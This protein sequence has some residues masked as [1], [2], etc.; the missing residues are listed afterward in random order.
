MDFRDSCSPGTDRFHKFS[1]EGTAAFKRQKRQCD[2]VYVTV[3]RLPAVLARHSWRMI[4]AHHKVTDQNPRL[5]M[6]SCCEDPF[7]I[8]ERM[9]PQR[10]FRQKPIGNGRHEYFNCQ[11]CGSHLQFI[12]SGKDELLDR[13]IY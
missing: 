7:L 10:L 11:N 8:R 12:Y 13:R 6:P 5:S 1:C 9:E 3:A 2:V 4:P